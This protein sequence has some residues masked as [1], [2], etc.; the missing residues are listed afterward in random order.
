MNG[1]QVDNTKPQAF[2]LQSGET[3]VA[4]IKRYMVVDPTGEIIGLTRDQHLASSLKHLHQF[5]MSHFSQLTAEEIELLSSDH[6]E[7]T[8][9][10][11]K[12]QK[13]GSKTKKGVLGKLSSTHK[14]L[15][16]K[17]NSVIAFIVNLGRTDKALIKEIQAKVMSEHKICENMAKDFSREL[18][19]NGLKE[20]LESILVVKNK[21]EDAESNF[22]QLIDFLSQDQ[23]ERLAREVE[24]IKNELLKKEKMIRPQKMRKQMKCFLKQ[25]NISE[26]DPCLIQETKKRVMQEHQVFIDIM[27]SSFHI[28]FNPKS[29]VSLFFSDHQHSSKRLEIG[30]NFSDRSIKAVA[31]YYIRSPDDASVAKCVEPY[32][33]DL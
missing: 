11:N 9:R 4:S 6:L 7:Q 30:T 32:I 29:E 31:G 5:V 17:L 15:S 19:R 33:Q 26:D 24:E 23:A 8:F 12:G 2:D 3:E 27:R 18:E 1:N 22:S 13:G 28:R 10:A 25:I 16:K 21:L 14:S 20:N